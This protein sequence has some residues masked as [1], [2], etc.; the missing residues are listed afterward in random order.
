M[1][2]GIPEAP[3]GNGRVVYTTTTL[4]SVAV[5][6]CRDDL[7]PV[8]TRICEDDGIWSGLIPFCIGTINVA[9][10]NYYAKCI[11]IIAAIIMIM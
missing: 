5:Y 7:S 11:I 2:C 9:N 6:F 3:F 4:G 10:I 8:L 1:N